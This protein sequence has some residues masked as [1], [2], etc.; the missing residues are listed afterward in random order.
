MLSRLDESDVP[1]SMLQHS[2]GFLAIFDCHK[3]AITDK[4]FLGY[5]EYVAE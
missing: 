4:Q 2:L 5:I 1:L 3:A